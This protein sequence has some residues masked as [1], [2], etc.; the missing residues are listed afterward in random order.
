M[1]AICADVVYSLILM[2]SPSS[3]PTMVIGWGGGGG[4][5][6][7]IRHWAFIRGERLIKGGRLLNTRHLFRIGRLLDHL[8]YKC[9]F[10]YVDATRNC[11]PAFTF[12]TKSSQLRLNELLQ[13]GNSNQATRKKVD[14]SKR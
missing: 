2:S 9:F 7:S 3:G 1:F 5:G 14:K 10:L 8:R 11:S 13:Y 12:A 6:G 4:G